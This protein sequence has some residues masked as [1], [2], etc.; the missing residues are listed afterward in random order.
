MRIKDA[1]LERTT[2]AKINKFDKAGGVN[3][4]VDTTEYLEIFKTAFVV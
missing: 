2:N 1:K 3:E 4:M